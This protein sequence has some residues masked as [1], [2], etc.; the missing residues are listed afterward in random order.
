MA[1][2]TPT[3]TLTQRSEWRVDQVV[4]QLLG[5]CVPVPGDHLGR[6]GAGVPDARSAVRGG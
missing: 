3:P 2:P 1:T 4:A 5:S 6:T